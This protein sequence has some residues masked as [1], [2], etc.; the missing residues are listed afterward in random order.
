MIDSAVFVGTNIFAAL[1]IKAQKDRDAIVAG[2]EYLATGM[3]LLQ[4][5][6]DPPQFA[7]P[8]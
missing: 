6:F 7:H 3:M 8:Y 5:H 4:L 1:K 2:P